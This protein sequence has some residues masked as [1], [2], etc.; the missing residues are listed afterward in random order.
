MQYNPSFSTSEK[1]LPELSRDRFSKNNLARD[2]FPCGGRYTLHGVSRS[3]NC[4]SGHIHT[5]QCS[6][7]M[8][9]SPDENWLPFREFTRLA[10]VKV[11]SS[12]N[13]YTDKKSLAYLSMK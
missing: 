6:V 2:G 3:K 1:V 8:L 9:L 10:F 11:V 13:H 12:C 7:L 5:I 4:S